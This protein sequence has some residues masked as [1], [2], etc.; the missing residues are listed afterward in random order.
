MVGETSGRVCGACHL[1]M[2]IA[3]YEEVVEDD[4]P[5]CINCAA[6]LVL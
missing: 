3:E 2:S 5:Q 1:E 4:L 6:I